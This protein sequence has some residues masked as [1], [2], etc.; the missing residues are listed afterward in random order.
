MIKIVSERGHPEN[1][2]DPIH[3]STQSFGQSWDAAICSLRNARQDCLKPNEDRVVVDPTRQSIVVA[4]GITRTKAADGSYPLVSPS[5]TVADLFCTTVS[6]LLASEVTISQATLQRAVQRGNEAIA[7]FNRERFP[8]ADFAENDIAGVA[9]IVGVVDGHRLWLA[10]IADCFSLSANSLSVERLA[11]E[12]TSHAADEYKRIGEREARRTLRNNPDSQYGYGAFTGEAVA[13]SFVQYQC[14]NI[15]YAK[16]LIFATDGLLPIADE[17]PTLFLHASTYQVMT[18][19]CELES[20]LGETD[21]KTLVI[22]D[23]RS[24]S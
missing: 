10:S 14:L 9:A 15:Q 11:W 1:K 16:R 13:L 8:N 19:A 20:R 6:D 24:Q 22:L 7:R 23:R 17:I 4:D 21:D 18:T 12:K 5:A 3:V 2:H